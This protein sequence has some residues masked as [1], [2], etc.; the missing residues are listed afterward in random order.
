V[1]A[2]KVYLVGFM[3]S[4]KTTVA[5]ALARHLDWQP[6]DIDELIEQREHDTV[7]GLF[8]RRGEPYFRSVERA[9]LLG[10]IGR[11][12]SVVATGGGTFVDPQNRAVIKGDGVSI[13]LD[14]PLE[15]VVARVPADGRRPLAADR[16]EFER[17]FFAR[18]A[19][20][21]EADLRIDAGRASVDAIVEQIADWL[22]QG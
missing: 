15:R 21:H 4:G 8:A 10:Q 14:V 18:Q 9:V 2:D 3:A 19:A 16:E 5:R 1:I 13:F 22:G 11:R 20:Y 7:A 12:F 6:I 17:L